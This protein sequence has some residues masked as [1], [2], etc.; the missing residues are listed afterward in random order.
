MTRTQHH[1]QITQLPEIVDDLRRGIISLVGDMGGL[2]QITGEVYPSNVIPGT[3]AIETEHGTIYRGADSNTL[4][5]EEHEPYPETTDTE[6]TVTCDTCSATSQSGWGDA[7]TC[8]ECTPAEQICSAHDRTTD[9]SCPVCS[10]EQSSANPELLY[11]INDTLAIILE[12]HF[13]WRADS[14]ADLS[15]L[16]T[17]THQ[18]AAVLTTLLH[19][20][21]ADRN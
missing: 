11:S 2:S 13:D 14:E 6:A 21:R 15:A 10:E 4:I 7:P 12:R 17:A 16:D 8:L 19:H 9:G 5:S 20:T 18:T 1:I 3:L